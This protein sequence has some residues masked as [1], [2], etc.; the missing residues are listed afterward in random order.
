MNYD[1]VLKVRKRLIEQKGV[2][3]DHDFGYF[4]PPFSSHLKKREEEN[5]NE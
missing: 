1:M 4:F 2:A 3:F 5:E